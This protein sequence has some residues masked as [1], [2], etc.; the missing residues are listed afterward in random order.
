MNTD[1]DEPEIVDKP[2][3]I[4]LDDLEV[5][6]SSEQNSP[7]NVG[8]AN[9]A[10]AT[11]ELTNE[12]STKAE[13]TEEPDAENH[14]AD[15]S[16]TNEQP[17]EECTILANQ[18]VSITEESSNIPSTSNPLT[19]GSSSNEPSSSSSTNEELNIIQGAEARM[20]ANESRRSNEYLQEE[21]LREEESDICIGKADLNLT[22]GALSL[23]ELDDNQVRLSWRPKLITDQEPS[24]FGYAIESKT[25]SGFWRQVCVVSSEE[26]EIVF[27]V[28][29]EDQLKFRIRAAEGEASSKSETDSPKSLKMAQNG[30]GEREEGGTKAS[31]PIPTSTSGSNEE[32]ALPAWKQKLIDKKVELKK[33]KEEEEETARRKWSELPDWKRKLLETKGKSGEELIVG[34]KEGATNEAAAENPPAAA[35]NNE[36]GENSLRAPESNGVESGDD[37]GDDSASE[38]SAGFWGVKL[39]KQR[40]DSNSKAGKAREKEEDEEAVGEGRGGRANYQDGAKRLWGVNLKVTEKG[41]SAKDRPASE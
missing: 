17:D 32:V 36:G 29:E 9:D 33:K 2:P 12:S 13:L 27:K 6:V 40:S 37:A 21:N 1:S 22:E 8:S 14:S 26:T 10:F 7:T 25:K 35:E 28:E 31:S 4:E 11:E 39:R 16:V 3:T 19:S 34:D 5:T 20:N 24:A 23:D 18:E 38:K 30:G 41:E 15:S